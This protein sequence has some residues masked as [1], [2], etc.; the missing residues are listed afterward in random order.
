M[1]SGDYHPLHPAHRLP[2]EDFTV[3]PLLLDLFCGA[4]GAAMG[5]HRAGFEVLGVDINPQPDYP[6]WF[7][8]DDALAFVKK[9]RPEQFA[10]VHASP[11]CPRYTTLAKGTNGNPDDYPDLIAPTRE[12]LI[13]TGLPYVI[14][15]VPAAP[16]RNPTTLCGEMFGLSVIRHRLFESNMLLMQPEHIAHRGRVAGYR[17]GKSFDGPYFA[18]YGDGG[19][20]G[21]VAEWQAAMGIDW[22]NNR[23]SIADAIPPAYTEYIGTQLLDAL[24]AVA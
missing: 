16:L 5:Y 15:N 11:P 7:T 3:K 20:K 22:T 18:V 14:E 4:G 24:K 1:D 9:W 12:L 2:V 8:Q 6:F 19:G 23:K 13:A 21:T 10:A 17:H